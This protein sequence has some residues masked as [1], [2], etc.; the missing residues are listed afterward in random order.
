MPGRQSLVRRS[1][2]DEWLDAD[3]NGAPRWQWRNAAVTLG[4]KQSKDKAASVTDPHMV[5]TASPSELSRTSSIGSLLALDTR[6]VIKYEVS[7]PHSTAFD[8]STPC[9]VID[10]Q[11]NNK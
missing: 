4:S 10:P 8:H 3:P 2:V 7:D 11:M 9:S 6:A 5:H 1:E